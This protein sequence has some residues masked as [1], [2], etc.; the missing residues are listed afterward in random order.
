MS[1]PTE[2]NNDRQPNT[3]SIASRGP[4]CRDGALPPSGFPP[5]GFANQKNDLL[6]RVNKQ[7]ERV[8]HIITTLLSDVEITDLST[9]ER[10]NFAIKFMTPYEH[11]LTLRHRT[12]DSPAERQFQALSR[13]IQRL[14][15]GEGEAQGNSIGCDGDEATH[16]RVPG[17]DG[18]GA[19]HEHDG[20]EQG[21]A[22]FTG[23]G[24]Y[25]EYQPGFTD[26]DSDEENAKDPYEEYYVDDVEYEG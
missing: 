9:T 19:A 14:L 20:D 21:Q 2:H 23:Y 15:L 1:N 5:S 12:Q 17:H 8:E 22:D 3:G 4:A 25:A 24:G 7:L 18:D 11:A 16:E 10:L 26:Y 6:E 13:Q